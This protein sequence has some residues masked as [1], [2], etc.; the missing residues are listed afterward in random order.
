LPYYAVT[1]GEPQFLNLGVS[2]ALVHFR[3][4]HMVESLELA[5]KQQLLVEKWFTFTL[6]LEVG[7]SCEQINA[8]PCGR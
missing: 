7:R 3:W 8:Y 2:N 4:Q 1:F 5:K 6:D